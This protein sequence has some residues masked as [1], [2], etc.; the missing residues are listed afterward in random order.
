M[1]GK[2]SVHVKYLVKL[3]PHIR[4]RNKDKSFKN[5]AILISNE[6]QKHN[7]TYTYNNVTELVQHC[8]LQ[9]LYLQ[10]L[11]LIRNVSICSVLC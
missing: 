9:N 3:Y 4:N 1:I 8:I 11:W 7:Y 5:A 2:H 6:P 10:V